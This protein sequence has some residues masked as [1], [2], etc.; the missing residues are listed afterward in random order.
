V[1]AERFEDQGTLDVVAEHGCTVLPLAPPVFPRWLRLPDL[2]QR[3]AGVRLV[4]SGTA[5]LDA[6]LVEAFSAA[7]GVVVHQGYGLTEAAGVVT[8]THVA[9]DP[10]PGSVGTPLPGVELRLVDDLGRA[11][12]AGDLGEVELRGDNLF[13]GYWPDGADGPDDDGWWRTG[14]VGHLDDRGNLVL[15]DRLAEVVVV[16]GFTVYPAEV[17]EVLREVPGVA[18][19]AVVGA[20]D[21]AT[22]EAVVAWVRPTDPAAVEAPEELL[23]ALAA[24]A[25]VRLARFKRPVRTQVVPELERTPTGKVRKGRLRGLERRRARGLVD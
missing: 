24:H 9:G 16:N 12:E 15:V 8:S 17:E 4:L 3:L 7:A 21:E 10:A 22:G 14:D 19:V 13:S 2:R 18:E 20:P 25:E 5:P 11:P 6:E 23:A 1:L